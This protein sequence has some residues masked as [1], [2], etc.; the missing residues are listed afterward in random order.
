MSNHHK[1]SRFEAILVITIFLVICGFGIIRQ[2]FGDPAYAEV[3]AQSHKRLQLQ[4][5]ESVRGWNPIQVVCDVETGTILY[6]V[7]NGG[8]IWGLPN[9]CQRDPH[10][11]KD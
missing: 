11:S 4:A 9:G 8:G 10:S 7:A 6:R 2:Y 1:L 5:E 3:E